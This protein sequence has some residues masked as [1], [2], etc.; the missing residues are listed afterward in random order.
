MKLFALIPAISAHSWL[1]CT[2]YGEKNGMYYDHDKCRGWPRLASQY[3]PIGGTFGGDSG[4]DTR[5]NSGSSPCA[6]ARSDSDYTGGHFEAVYFPG[7]QVVLAHPM[8]NHGTGSCTNKYIPDNGNWLYA[9]PMTTPGQPDPN[10]GEF[11]E[12]EVV[13]LGVSPFGHNVPDSEINSYPKEGFANA[14]AFCEDTNLALGTYSF[15]VPADM[16]TG[17]YTFAWLWAFN[18]ATDYYSTCFEVIVV[19]NKAERQTTLANRGQTDFSLTCDDGPTSNGSPGSTAGCDGA[20]PTDPPTTPPTNPPMT[21]NPPT[22]GPMD[23]S[24]GHVITT[25]M[26]G[27]LILPGP[28]FPPVQREIHV[29]FY[30]D[31]ADV[32]RPNFWYARLDHKHDQDGNVLHRFRRSDGGGASHVVHYVLIQENQEDIQRGYIGYHWAF[33]NGCMMLQSPSDLHVIDTYANNV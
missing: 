26:T 5:P 33:E 11:K 22:D 2:D 24:M 25:Q 9:Q 19:A 32:A 18:S 16:A 13:N 27:K 31:C 28:T 7:Q 12:N 3:A 6:S 17:R 21:N 8:K 29:K 4:Y 15:N 14:P 30:A 1:A 10:L 23:G 20:P